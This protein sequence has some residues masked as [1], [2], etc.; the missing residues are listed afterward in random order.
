[1]A[2][3][4][5]IKDLI[6]EKTSLEQILLRVKALLFDLDN[7][8]ILEWVDNELTGYKRKEEVPAYRKIR[9]HP[10]F[11]RIEQKGM[12]LITHNDE[13]IPFHLIPEGTLS[14]EILEKLLIFQDD[15]SLREI[16]KMEKNPELQNGS[17]VTCPPE[18]NIILERIYPRSK[19][20]NL[21]AILSVGSLTNILVNIKN[22]LLNMLLTLEREY[23][24]LD[25]YDIFAG[26]TKEEKE[27]AS[28][29]IIKII[30][31]DNNIITGSNLGEING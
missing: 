29:K 12:N 26:R 13:S 31:G 5:I 7:N 14:E 18:C 8:T 28:Q 9:V 16:E 25:K 4:E 2:R 27:E 24:D 6:E 10:T 17:G 11:K 23:G 30:I 21:H 22:K 20:T 3:S 19:I 1:M 15:R